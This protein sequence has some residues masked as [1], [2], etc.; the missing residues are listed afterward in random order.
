MYDYVVK[1]LPELLR[2]HFPQ[3]DTA[4]A[5]IFGHSMGGHGALTIFLKNRDKYKVG[6]RFRVGAFVVTQRSNLLPLL[7]KCKAEIF[8]QKVPF[9]KAT[10]SSSNLWFV[11]T[12]RTWPLVRSAVAQN[13]SCCRQL[14]L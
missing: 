7:S 3:L 5:S 1:E 14:L 13:L 2:T 4:N 8:S 6:F 11:K 10:I 9:Q 12:G